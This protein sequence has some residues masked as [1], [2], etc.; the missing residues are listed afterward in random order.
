MILYDVIIGWFVLFI[1]IGLFIIQDQI[2]KLYESTI[3]DS[4]RFTK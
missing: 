1:A 3:N 4:K 2:C